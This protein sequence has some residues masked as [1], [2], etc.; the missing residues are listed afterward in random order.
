MEGAC[1]PMAQETDEWD[2][3]LRIFSVRHYYPR[4]LVFFTNRGMRDWR[5][6]SFGFNHRHGSRLEIPEYPPLGPASSE[7]PGLEHEYHQVPGALDYFSRVLD[8]ILEIAE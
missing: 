2:V 5:H 6:M 8:D 7:G 4:T 1:L 3:I